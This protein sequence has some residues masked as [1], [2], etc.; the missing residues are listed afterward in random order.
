MLQRDLRME[1]FKI[2]EKLIEM[3]MK[4]DDDD[5]ILP[6]FCLYSLAKHFSISN[7]PAW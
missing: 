6:A 4:H 3:N 5:L 7:F 1:N 2:S